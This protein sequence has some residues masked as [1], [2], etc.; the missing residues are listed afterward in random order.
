MEGFLIRRL[1]L[2]IPGCGGAS[3]T[4]PSQTLTQPV[5]LG[6]PHLAGRNTPGGVSFRPRVVRLIDIWMDL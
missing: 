3:T 5:G 2:I 1:C 6:F 4:S